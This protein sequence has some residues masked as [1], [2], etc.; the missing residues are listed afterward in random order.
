MDGFEAESPDAT[1]VGQVPLGASSRK[2][3]EGKGRKGEDHKL[4][5]GK[6]PRSGNQCHWHCG[7]AQPVR[8]GGMQS[9]GSGQTDTWLHSRC[10][11]S[12][13]AK[14]LASCPFD[15][16]LELPI[17]RCSEAFSHVS[18]AHPLG[19]TTGYPG[20]TDRKRR[21]STEAG[22]EGT[23]DSALRC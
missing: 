9:T 14:M 2:R 20:A 17:W 5:L 8:T 6:A 22:E 1:R 13:P 18:G 21:L 16:L 11:N 12:S 15:F 3:L 10:E 4:Q 7:V 23:G 19:S